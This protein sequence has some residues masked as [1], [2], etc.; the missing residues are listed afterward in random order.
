MFSK[1][2]T[3]DISFRVMDEGKS[4]MIYAS[5]AGYKCF[6]CGDIGHKRTTCPHKVQVNMNEEDN[7]DNVVSDVT[8]PAGENSQIERTETVTEQAIAEGH[9]SDNKGI[10][11]QENAVQD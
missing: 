2:P 9:E 1:E 3:L 5:T 7:V 6:E 8:E 11:V 10:E 4:F